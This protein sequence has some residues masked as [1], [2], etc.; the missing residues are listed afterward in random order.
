MIKKRLIY[1][2]VK[3]NEER[4]AMHVVIPHFLII[5]GSLYKIRK[6]IS[7]KNVNNDLKTI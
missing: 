2:K 4:F 3:H 6:K 5:L 7:P 1:S